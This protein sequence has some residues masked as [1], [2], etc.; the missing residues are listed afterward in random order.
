MDKGA[1]ELYSTPGEGGRGRGRAAGYIPRRPGGT[2]G[3]NPAARLDAA[4]RP[5]VWPL[6]RGRACRPRPRASRSRMGRLVPLVTAGLALLP[7][8]VVV[9]APAGDP[10][11]PA[12][13]AAKPAAAEKFATHR[14]ITR[15]GE[16]VRV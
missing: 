2:A 9:P 8:C 12:P 1:P 10:P 13:S 5:G 4:R 6:P 3:I 15:P 7:G 16:V 11:A 14:T